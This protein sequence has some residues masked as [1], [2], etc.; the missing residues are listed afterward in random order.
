MKAPKPPPIAFPEDGLIRGFYTREPA[1]AFE[2]IDCLEDGVSGGRTRSH[3]VRN[4]ALRQ[5]EIMRERKMNEREA[6]KEMRR[7]RD[8]RKRER[9]RRRRERVNRWTKARV[10]TAPGEGLHGEFGS[11]IERIQAAEEV[12]WLEH[13]ESARR[14]SG[15][16]RARAS[17]AARAETT[18]MTTRRR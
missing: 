3:Y 13:V 17:R 12:R 11:E 1:A 14:A 6:L 10:L 8:A 5:L 15:S 9:S 2:A 4:F 18:T 7:E 16:R